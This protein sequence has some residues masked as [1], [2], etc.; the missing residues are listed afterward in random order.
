MQK[1]VE[2]LS[3]IEAY[4]EQDDVDEKIRSYFER[5]KQLRRRIKKHLPLLELMGDTE[6]KGTL[7]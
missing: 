7:L 3:I 4:E 5:R 2:D 6:E 1:P